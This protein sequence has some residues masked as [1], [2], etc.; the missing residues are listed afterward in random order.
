MTK[1]IKI[2]IFIYLSLINFQQLNKKNFL[3]YAQNNNIYLNENIN[4]QN[5]SFGL[6]AQK[7]TYCG[8]LSIYTKN[9]KCALS[10]IKN[11]I[12]PIIDLTS[13][14]NI[15]NKFNKTSLKKN[16]WEIYFNQPYGFSLN[17]VKSKSKNIVPIECRHF[18]HRDFDQIYTNSFFRKFWSNLSQKYYPVKNEIIMKAEHIKSK[19]FQYSNNILGVLMRGTDFISAKPKNHYIPPTCEIVFKDII[20]MDQKNKYD[21]IF[22]ATEDNNIRKKFINRFKNKIK[23]YTYR[24]EI[25]YDYKKKHLLASNPNVNSNFEFLKIYLINI[26]ILSK[27]LDLLSAKTNGAIAIF[28]FSKGFRFSKVYDLG[29][30]K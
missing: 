18:Y 26:I 11:G 5:Y 13:T 12:I 22:I 17:E 23:Y 28:L 16:P 27:C 21:Y 25:K 15:F 1:L 3:S 10:S 19:L 29:S 4:I 6:I 20:N 7:C 14:P 9:L 24:K 30:Y 8:L 2:F